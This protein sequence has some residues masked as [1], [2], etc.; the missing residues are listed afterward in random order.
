MVVSRIFILLKAGSSVWGHPH[1]GTP[2]S[3]QLS[4]SVHLCLLASPFQGPNERES[5]RR[6]RLPNLPTNQWQSRLAGRNPDKRRESRL[7]TFIQRSHQ[8]RSTSTQQEGRGY[9]RLPGH[10]ASWTGH[11]II[12]QNTTPDCPA[13][14]PHGPGTTHH[15]TAPYLAHI[16]YLAPSPC[17]Y[18]NSSPSVHHIIII[19][20][21][22]LC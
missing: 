13:T 17:N 9:A 3:I 11:F 10:D 21:I 8:V 4:R 19:T 18:I 12:Q 5:L 14:M 7:R 22:S 2:S 15:G 20:T 1:N 6:P 16:I